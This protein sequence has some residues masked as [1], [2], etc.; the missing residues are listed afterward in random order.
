MDEEA[1]ALERL[2]AEIRACRICEVHLP[3]GPNPV[4]RAARTARVLIVGQAPG[5]R[6]HATGIPWP[7]TNQRDVVEIDRITAKNLLTAGG[8]QIAVRLCFDQI[9]EHPSE[10]FGLLEAFGG[11]RLLQQG[12]A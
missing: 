12:Q 9:P 11:A 5:T 4:L 7:G 6:V 10:L 2:L 3:L 8:G 1:E